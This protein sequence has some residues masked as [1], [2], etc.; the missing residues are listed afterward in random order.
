MEN[1]V[2]SAMHPEIVGLIENPMCV[3]AF[4]MFLQ[5]FY[6]GAMT[7]KETKYAMPVLMLA[8]KYKVKVRDFTL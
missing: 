2:G 8:K 5:Y 3:E 1:S 6:T 7:V 4:P